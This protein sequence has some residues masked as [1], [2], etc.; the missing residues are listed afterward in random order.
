MGRAI[1][2][3]PR[4][5]EPER[6]RSARDGSSWWD[7][8]DADDDDDDDDADDDDDRTGQ[9]RTRSLGPEAGPRRAARRRL[10]AFSS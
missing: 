4:Q 7:D 3:A 6:A 8:D 10:G 9:D 5:V 2:W 1:R